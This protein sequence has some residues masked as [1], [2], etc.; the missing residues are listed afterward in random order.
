MTYIKVDLSR[1]DLDLSR[2]FKFKSMRLEF[3]VLRIVLYLA[4]TISILTYYFTMPIVQR[5][6]HSRHIEV[7]LK[8]MGQHMLKIPKV[9]GA[10]S[11]I[12]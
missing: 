10:P 3:I 4:P 6:C 11:G 12:L 9:P 5:I 8:L 2:S 1:I 7:H